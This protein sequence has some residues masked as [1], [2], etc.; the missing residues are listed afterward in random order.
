MVIE[1]INATDVTVFTFLPLSA[2]WKK[3]GQLNS[4]HLRMLY[5]KFVCPVCFFSLFCHYLPWKKAWP[6]EFLHPKMLWSRFGWNWPS[7][8]GVEDGIVKSLQFLIEK[9]TYH[10]QLKWLKISYLS[11]LWKNKSPSLKDN[12]VSWFRRSFKKFN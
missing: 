5:G 8:S 2:L 1:K 3:Y 10:N 12:F 7:G 6:L 9:L 11:F 4:L